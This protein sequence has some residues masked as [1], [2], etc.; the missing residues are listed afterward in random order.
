MEIEDV[1]RDSD[2]T[3]IIRLNGFNFAFIKELCGLLKSDI[4]IMF[5]QFHGNAC[6]PKTIMSIS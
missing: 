2:G 3:K 6:L 4:R 1:V 5:G